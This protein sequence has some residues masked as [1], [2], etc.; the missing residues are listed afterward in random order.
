[1]HPPEI[2]ANTTSETYNVDKSTSTL[3]PGWETW[4]HEPPKLSKRVLGL[5]GYAKGG[6]AVRMRNAG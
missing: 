4:A 2:H 1:M 3:P 6:V 5:D